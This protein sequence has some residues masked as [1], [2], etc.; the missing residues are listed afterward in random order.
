MEI[1]TL[2]PA[3]KIGSSPVALTMPVN[4]VGADALVSSAIFVSPV[5]QARSFF[6]Y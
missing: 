3:I 1:R 5:S 6:P 2:S 4:L